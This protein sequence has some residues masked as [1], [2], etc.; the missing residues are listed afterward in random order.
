MT[1]PA[2][3]VRAEVVSA[4][5]TNL[6]DLMTKPAAEGEVV[7]VKSEAVVFKAVPTTKTRSDSVAV[8]TTPVTKPA[9]TA[10]KAAPPQPS[11]VQQVGTAPLPKTHRNRCRWISRR[12]P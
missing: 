11:S 5:P 2:G 9:W 1:V 8:K 6:W 10:K 3:E 12:R 7:A 4:K